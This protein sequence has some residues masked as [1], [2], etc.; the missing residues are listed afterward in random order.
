M[1]DLDSSQNPQ[2]THANARQNPP[3]STHQNPSPN[4]RQPISI[5]T[6]LEIS[7]DDFLSAPML[8]LNILPVALGV[9][10]WVGILYGFSDTILSYL[11]HFLP[12]S[13][14]L[15]LESASF[16]G[17]GALNAIL[18]AILYIMLGFLAILLAIVGNLFISIFYTPIAVS[19][20]RKRHYAAAPKSEGA[21]LLAALKNF[22][23]SL[24]ILC[25]VCVVCIP[26][27]FVPLVGGLVMLAPFFMFFYKTTFFDV[28]CEVL[29]AHR[30]AEIWQAKCRYRVAF[31]AYVMG[32]VPI[33]GFF[34]PLFQ[35]I[36]I[37]HF[38]FMQDFGDADSSTRESK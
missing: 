1:N 35:V 3:R 4:P 6:L 20:V 22:S 27:L 2:N 36:M 37:S 25:I 18:W 17:V 26:L 33:L 5:R 12:E 7:K 30:Y 16:W 29:G 14:R 23:I 34:M 28:G 13:W 11:T 38:Y 19:Y 31:A 15:S 10:F 8:M 24:A 21:P 32:L 9:L